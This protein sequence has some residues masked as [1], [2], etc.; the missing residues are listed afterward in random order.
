MD[1]QLLRNAYLQR[2]VDDIDMPFGKFAASY[3]GVK[4]KVLERGENVSK[5]CNMILKKGYNEYKVYHGSAPDNSN[6]KG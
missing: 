3:L 4:D 6:S 5:A 1:T 2:N